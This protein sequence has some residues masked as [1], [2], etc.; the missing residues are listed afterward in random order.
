MKFLEMSNLGRRVNLQLVKELDCGDQ[1]HV[2]VTTN[3]RGYEYE[4]QSFTD[5]RVQH[6]SAELIVLSSGNVQITHNDGVSDLWH[7]PVE[8]YRLGLAMTISDFASDVVSPQWR[9]YMSI[10]PE[11][12]KRIATYFRSVM[13]LIL[14]GRRPL[15]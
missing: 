1:F 5:S 3:P 9:L 12:P 8:A 2:T 15:L 14:D 10:D 13:Q 4:I 6:V 11:V 7:I